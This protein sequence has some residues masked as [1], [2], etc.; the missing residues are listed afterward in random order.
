M[1]ITSFQINY[2]NDTVDFVE[3][4]GFWSAAILGMANAIKEGRQP[5]IRNVLN[6][7]TKKMAVNITGPSY[8][9]V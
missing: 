4:I 5:E 3:A 2:E 9:I 7:E 6:T 8:N 1:K